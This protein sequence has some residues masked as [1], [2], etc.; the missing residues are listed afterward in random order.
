MRV[1][2]CDGFTLALGVAALA[3]LIASVVLAP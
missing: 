1:L 2:T 3:A